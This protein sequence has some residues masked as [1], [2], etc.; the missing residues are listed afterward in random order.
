MKIESEF[1]FLSQSQLV[2]YYSF[3]C[4]CTCCNNNLRHS[5]SFL[6]VSNSILECAMTKDTFDTGHC[7]VHEYYINVSSSVNEYYINV[8]SM[9]TI[10]SMQTTWNRHIL[11]HE[12]QYD[13]LQDIE[14]SVKV[15]RMKLILQVFINLH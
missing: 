8:S 15:I 10:S 4:Y 11:R 13:F 2:A 7:V 9:S 1:I 5:I 14:K 6:L 3:F 12:R